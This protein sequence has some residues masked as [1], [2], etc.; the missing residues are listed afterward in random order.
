M[1][2][3]EIS[4]QG[5]TSEFPPLSYRFGFHSDGHWVAHVEETSSLPRPA[6]PPRPPHCTGAPCDRTDASAAGRYGTTL[7]SLGNL[8]LPEGEAD[9]VVVH[10]RVPPRGAVRRRRL[11]GLRA[12]VGLM[13]VQSV[14]V[15]I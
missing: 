11:R 6:P 3:L 4:C 8:M 10:P 1:E 9:I 2:P 15:L 14:R 13:P 12:R 7:E 5:W